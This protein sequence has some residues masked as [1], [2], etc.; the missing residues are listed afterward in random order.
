MSS[1]T[2]VQPKRTVWAVCGVVS[3]VS[4]QSP[5]PKWSTGEH[6][7]AL[8][9]S[10]CDCLSLRPHL[11]IVVFLDND[12]AILLLENFPDS[13]RLQLCFLIH[14][15]ELPYLQGEELCVGR[16]FQHPGQNT[17]LS[18][19]SSTLKIHTNLTSYGSTFILVSEFVFI[20]LLEINIRFILTSEICFSHDE[21]VSYLTT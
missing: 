11:P 7:P 14:S 20:N 13:H 4:G 21:T 3:S 17:L 19:S 6:K 12:Q 2:P 18:I 9:L 8:S 15:Q 5:A 1:L 16:G 10:P